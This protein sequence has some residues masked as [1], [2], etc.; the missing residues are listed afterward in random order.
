MM[1]TGCFLHDEQVQIPL[2]RERQGKAGLPRNGQGSRS[3]AKAQTAKDPATVVS[4]LDFSL[5]GI[6]KGPWYLHVDTEDCFPFVMGRIT[7]RF[8]TRVTMILS[9]AQRT[10]VHDA[11]VLFGRTPG[12]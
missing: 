9:L 4:A 7:L 12:H 11:S 1:P 5:A 2:G 3:V 6:R 10:T 8:T